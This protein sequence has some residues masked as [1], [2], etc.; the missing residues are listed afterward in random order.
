MSKIRPYH[1]VAAR[2]RVRIHA[3][4]GKPIDAKTEKLAALDIERTR[5][6]TGTPSPTEFRIEWCGNVQVHIPVTQPQPDPHT[7]RRELSVASA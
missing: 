2:A 1:I 3:D 5:H 6:M 7:L 4:L